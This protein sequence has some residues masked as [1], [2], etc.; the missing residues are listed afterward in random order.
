[1]RKLHLVLA[2]LI[3]ISSVSL[4]GDIVGKVK[5]KGVKHSGDAVIYVEKI[6]SKTFAP[7]KEHPKFDQK[8]LMFHPHV[9]PIVVGSTVD[10]LNSDDVLHNVFSPDQC[11]EK[12]NLGTWP[13]G[14][15]RSYTFKNPGCVPVM[16]CNVHPEM[17]AYVIVLETPYYAVSEKD[18]S[19]RIKDVPA[20]SYTLKIW[21]E[22]LKGESV[23]V[24]VPEKGEATVDFGLKK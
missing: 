7:Q 19:Y 6:P 17:E 15:I 10:F 5:A 14:Q 18:G 12:F 20:G 21:H 24:T 4:A 16:L 1:M 13:K 23:S 11:A 8:N 22:K 9:L 3:C 2:L